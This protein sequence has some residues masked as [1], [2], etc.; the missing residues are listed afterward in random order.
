MAFGYRGNRGQRIALQLDLTSCRSVG[1]TLERCPKNMTFT[2]EIR[3][4][5]NGRVTGLVTWWTAC[6][7]QGWRTASL[8]GEF[9]H[10]LTQGIQGIWILMEEAHGHPCLQR[11]HFFC[12]WI[13][14]QS[15]ELLQVRV[16]S[17]PYLVKSA[18]FLHQISCTIW[19]NLRGFSLY[20]SRYFLSPELQGFF[21]L[22][23]GTSS[24]ISDRSSAERSAKFEGDCSLSSNDD[25]KQSSFKGQL[26]LKSF[27]P[28]TLK[29]TCIS[30]ES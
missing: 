2:L 22:L 1:I 28:Q 3:S 13:R 14:W 6:S 12:M 19:I 26:W 27:Q 5:S 20:P 8:G 4:T 11:L 23:D 18:G 29:A 16:S 25:V 9:H 15:F 24:N 7:E 30:K 17:G 10:L 21:P